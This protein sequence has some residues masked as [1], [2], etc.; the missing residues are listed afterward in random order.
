ME[1]DAGTASFAGHRHEMM[2]G[3]DVSRELVGHGSGPVYAV[4]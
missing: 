4:R 2:H 3:G 1:K